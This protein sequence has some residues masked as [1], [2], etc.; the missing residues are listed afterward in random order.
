MKKF[1]FLAMLVITLFLIAGAIEF[2]RFNDHKLHIIFCN[3]GQGDAIFIRTPSGKDILLDGGPDH[4]VLSC[5]SKHMPFWDRKIEL[6]LLSHPH[7][8]HFAG[9]IFVLQ[10]Y[11]TK[12]FGTE[13]LHNETTAFNTLQEE[14]TRRKIPQTSLLKGDVFRLADGVRI[15]V[16]GPSSEFL[17]TTSPNGRIGEK[18]EFAS[19]VFR[20][21]YKSFSVLF[22]GDSQI[23]GLNDAA[24]SPVSVLQIPHHG[25]KTGVD[26]EV[27]QRLKPQLAVISV[28]KNNYGHPSKEVI[29]LLRNKDIKVLRTDLDGEVEVITDG[30]TW[31]IKH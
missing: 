9:L 17:H 14:L 18:S 31:S 4:S 5:L 26:E 12:Q 6:M 11:I 10:R 25:S 3:V 16:L 24:S 23:V 21:S 19:L 20:L 15:E 22:T 2:L 27:I 13:D 1:I 29:K 7:L 30:Q 8:D 28:G